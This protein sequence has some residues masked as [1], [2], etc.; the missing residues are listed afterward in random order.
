MSTDVAA[1]VS[2]SCEQLCLHFSL[3]ALPQPANDDEGGEG[4][5]PAVTDPGPSLLEFHVRKFM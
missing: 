3:Q 1:A 2:D 5:V 4:Y